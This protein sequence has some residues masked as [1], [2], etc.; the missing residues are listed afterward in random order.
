MCHTTGKHISTKKQLV[1]SFKSTGWILAEFSN[2]R[3]NSCRINDIYNWKGSVSVVFQLRECWINM[4]HQVCNCF[5][6]ESPAQKVNCKS[7]VFANRS[8]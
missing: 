4:Q 3:P 2:G 1:G 6:F 7:S 5:V 8:L